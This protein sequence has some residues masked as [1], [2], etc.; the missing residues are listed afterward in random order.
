M[1]GTYPISPKWTITGLFNYHTGWPTTAV[2]G[3]AVVD[4]DGELVKQ[5]DMMAPIMKTMAGKG[6]GGRM[7]AIRELQDKGLVD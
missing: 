6:V 7:Q 5:Y 2:S 3:R 1:S 4:P